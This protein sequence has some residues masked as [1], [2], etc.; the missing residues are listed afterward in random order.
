MEEF[1]VRFRQELR[2]EEEKVNK[3]LKRERETLL[4]KRKESFDERLKRMEGLA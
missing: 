3:K 1:E 4:R 2:A